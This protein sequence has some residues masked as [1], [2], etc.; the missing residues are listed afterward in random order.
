MLLTEPPLP[1]G[2]AEPAAAITAHPAPVPPDSLYLRGTVHTATGE[3]QPGLHLAFRRLGLAAQTDSN[4]EFF[5][6]IP[7]R[8]AGRITKDELL[9]THPNCG[10]YRKAVNLF[11]AGPIHIMVCESSPVGVECSAE[12]IFGKERAR[13]LRQEARRSRSRP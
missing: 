12:D 1:G 10:Q 6:A 9:L 2:A 11:A 8:R 7:L 13:R 5:F 3:Q 4:G